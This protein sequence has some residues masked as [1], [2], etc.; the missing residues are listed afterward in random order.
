MASIASSNVEKL[1]EFWKLEGQL[2][3]Q[4]LLSQKLNLNKAK[5]VIMFLGDG[6]SFSTVAA[7]RMLLG[8]EEQFLSFEKF[9]HFGFS[10]VKPPNKIVINNKISRASHTFF[11]D[12][13]C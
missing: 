5:N 6:M 3:L 4:Q 7:T 8:G 9:P 12:L 2:K 11:T 10:K 13:L 1:P